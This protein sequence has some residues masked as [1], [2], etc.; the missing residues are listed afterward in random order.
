VKQHGQPLSGIAQEGRG[1]AVGD[2]DA[3]MQPEEPQDPPGRR[4]ARSGKCER[5]VDTRL[6]KGGKHSPLLV[7]PPVL[8]RLYDDQYGTG[9]R[10]QPGSCHTQGIESAGPEFCVRGRWIGSP[11]R[12]NGERR[13]VDGSFK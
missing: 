4:A 2:G 10:L 3:G 9:T 8:A 1:G 5:N 7:F 12:R 6:V 11:P 13:L